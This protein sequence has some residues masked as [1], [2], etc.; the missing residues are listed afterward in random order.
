[1]IHVLFIP[2]Y[3]MKLASTLRHC[4]SCDCVLL[5]SFSKCIIKSHYITLNHQYLFG[6][7]SFYR[8]PKIASHSIL[9]VLSNM[10][11]KKKGGRLCLITFSQKRSIGLSYLFLQ[12]CL[13][14]SLVA[15]TRILNMFS[16]GGAHFISCIFYNLKSL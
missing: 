5:P 15:K 4:S 7:S 6:E 16:L 12:F 11:A 9:S 8:K 2:C 3:Y 10:L 1:M 14:I 13:S